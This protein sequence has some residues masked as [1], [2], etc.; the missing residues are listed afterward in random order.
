MP[1][2]IVSFNS[3]DGIDKIAIQEVFI[4]E[5]D[6]NTSICKAWLLAGVFSTCGKTKLNGSTSIP[7]HGGNPAFDVGMIT[8]HGLSVGSWILQIECCFSASSNNKLA[9]SSCPNQ[10]HDSELRRDITRAVDKPIPCLTYQSKNESRTFRRDSSFPYNSVRLN[11][12][13]FHHPRPWKH[14]GSPH[15]LSRFVRTTGL[16]ACVTQRH[17]GS[18]G[19]CCKWVRSKSAKRW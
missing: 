7:V 8:Q 11:A 15:R 12:R 5:R 18:R 9:S 17:P 3:L 6:A 1:D 4:S 14:D 2:R 10:E 13:P 16:R 19:I